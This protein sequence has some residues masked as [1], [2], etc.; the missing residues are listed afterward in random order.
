MD[1]SEWYSCVEGCG[2]EAVAERV[3]GD[4]LVDS[5]VFSEASHHPGC[6]VP[7]HSLPIAGS[8]DGSFGSL[9]DGEV[10][11][12]GGTRR[13]GDNDGLT[14]FSMDP[15]RVMAPLEADISDI[16]AQGFRDAESVQCE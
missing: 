15:Q 2:D 6:L 16:G 10:D 7:V 11:G 1:V 3:G 8:E 13:H 9:A 14:A 5:G 12:A 4:L